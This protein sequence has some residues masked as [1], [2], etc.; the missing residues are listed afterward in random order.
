MTE[1]LELSSLVR[2]FGTAERGARSLTWLRPYSFEFLFQRRDYGIDL[3]FG[4]YLC[5][6]RLVQA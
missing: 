6:N 4:S 2:M 3:E 5:L 1:F